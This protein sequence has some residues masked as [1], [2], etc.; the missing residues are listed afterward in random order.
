MGPVGSQREATYDLKHAIPAGSWHV[1]MDAVIL[2]SVDDGDFFELQPEYA[3]NILTGFAR[4]DGQTVGIV[5]NQPLVL[6][7]ITWN[8]QRHC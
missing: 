8:A 6:A 3:R 7:G 4:M 5:A 2:K 1:V